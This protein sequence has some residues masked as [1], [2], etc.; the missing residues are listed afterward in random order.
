[1]RRRW[2]LGLLLGGLLL[3]ALWGGVVGEQSHLLLPFLRQD[4]TWQA[5]Q[6]RGLWRVGLDPSF[7]PFELLDATGKVVGYDVALAEALAASWGGRVEIV[8]VGFD[9]LPDTLKAGKIDSIV[10]A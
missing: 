2:V 1:M 9:S 10:S 8:A 4:T 5:I 6:Q 7:P 3:P